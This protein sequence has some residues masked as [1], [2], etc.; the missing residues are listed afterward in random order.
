L[1]AQTGGLQICSFGAR[2]K[3]AMQN[4]QEE[5]EVIGCFPKNKIKLVPAPYLF[6]F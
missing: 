1:D 3:E 4:T 5:D 2:S 6:H